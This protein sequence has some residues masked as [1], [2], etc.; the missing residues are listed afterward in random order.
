MADRRFRLEA[1]IRAVDQATG[2][3]RRIGMAASR[4]ARAT[5]LD[6]V[7]G[8]AA[9]SGRALVGVA[10]AARA[11]VTP[12]AAVAGAAGLLIHRFTGA[13]DTLAKTSDRLGIGIEALQRLRYAGE[14]AGVPIRTMD[15]GLRVF[16]RRLAEAAAGGGEA[17]AALQHLGIQLTDSAGRMRPTTDL[18][19]DVADAISLIEDESVQVALTQ[20]LFDSEGIPIL[21][22]LKK[23]SSGIRAAGDELERLGYITEAEAR[24]AERWTDG[25]T[26][27]GRVV[28]HIGY[29]IAADLLPHLEPLVVDLRELAIEARPRVLE[30]MRESV[31]QLGVAI[32]WA[33]AQWA[34]WTGHLSAGWRV[35][36]LVAPVL[37]TLAA[38]LA[39]LAHRLGVWRIALLGALGLIGGRLL[40]SV[41]VLAAR[42]VQL[43]GAVDRKSVV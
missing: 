15:T 17:E 41:A 36:L 7:A 2:P 33:R 25:M 42:L 11:T 22:L 38:W 10:A 27:L 24:A 20:R 23:Q 5:G 37:G 16:T 6:R 4:A 31:R 8:A 40:W 12:I 35:L 13:A 32:A 43:A 26:R 19:E 34:A 3:I 21:N 14:L 39:R 1:V 9:G 18:M 28:T 30:W 29:T